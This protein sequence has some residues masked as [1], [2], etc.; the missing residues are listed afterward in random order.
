MI[1][2][3]KAKLKFELRTRPPLSGS[4]GKM[5]SPSL[6]IARAAKSRPVTLD[7]SDAIIFRGVRVYGITGRELWRTWYKTAAL[8][9]EG[10]DVSPIITHK[11]PLTRY[12]DA[13]DLLA[14]GIAGKVVLLPGES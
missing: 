6:L 7:L 4:W 12:A 2:L 13:F 10:L 1:R 14:Q 11:L 8:L 3:S 5:R 9:R